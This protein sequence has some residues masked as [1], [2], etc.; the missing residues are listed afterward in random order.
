MMEALRSFA[1]LK[2]KYF[3]LCI[4]ECTISTLMNDYIT[5]WVLHITKLIL[6]FHWA[7]NACTR[8]E[9]VFRQGS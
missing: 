4:V 6:K 2:K 9:I 5:R 8:S 7:A 3:H 1:L